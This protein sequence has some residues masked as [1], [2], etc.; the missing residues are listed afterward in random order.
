MESLVVCRRVAMLRVSHPCVTGVSCA[1]RAF[2]AGTLRVAKAV[3]AIGAAAN[4]QFDGQLR[5]QF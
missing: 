5:P 4:V 1:Q 2:Y 3:Q